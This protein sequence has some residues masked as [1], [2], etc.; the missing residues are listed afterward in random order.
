[1]ISSELSLNQFTAHQ[2]L[3]R[4]L[5]IRKCP[6]HKAVSINEFLADKSIP[7]VSQSPID[8]I[9]VPVTHLKGRHLGALDNIQKSV[10]NK[11]KSITAEAFQHCYEQWLQRLCHC[12]RE[13]F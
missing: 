9:S 4:D 7:V 11:L 6:C 12:P 10:T 8:Q 13:L 5:C 2:I 1:M 3:T